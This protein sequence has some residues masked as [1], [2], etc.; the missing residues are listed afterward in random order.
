MVWCTLLSESLCSSRLRFS[1]T[2]DLS[3]LSI[4]GTSSLSDMAPPPLLR[5][6][7]NVWINCTMENGVGKMVRETNAS[8]GLFKNMLELEP[9]G[10]I[11]P[12]GL[13]G[14]SR[15][16]HEQGGSGAMIIKAAKIIHP[17]A[18]RTDTAA[19]SDDDFVDGFVCNSDLYGTR[20][21]SSL[22]SALNRYGYT[23]FDTVPETPQEMTTSEPAVSPSG[24]SVKFMITRREV[25]ELLALG[26]SQAE[27]N[28]FKPQE[29]A[30]ILAIGKM[31][32]SKG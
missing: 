21:T 22:L 30:D 8:G 26:Y 7:G 17:D 4:D 18:S 25:Q 2:S 14:V 3:R 27:V 31:R 24:A 13:S 16:G 5:L 1:S 6:I 28:A 10:C 32:G 20:S 15:Y 12:P 9:I 19:G 29:A 23:R 11:F